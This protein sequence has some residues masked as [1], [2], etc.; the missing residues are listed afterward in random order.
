MI[1]NNKLFVG[2]LPF[3]VT[4]AQLAE[5]FSQAGT[6]NSANIATDRATGRARGFGFVEMSNQQEAES[7]IRD[8]DGHS[9]GGRQIS[10]RISE[11]KPRTG[12][13]YGR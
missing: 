4:E 11:P 12:G 3:S 8:L 9:L 6:V 1:M 13:G 2:N 7:A 10:V 5:V